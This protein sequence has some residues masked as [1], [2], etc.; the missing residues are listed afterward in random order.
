MSA[1][2]KVKGCTHV[3]SVR[4]KQT[5]KRDTDAPA[6]PKKKGGTTMSEVHLPHQHSDE[7][8]M[9][10][11]QE[12]VE[13]IGSFQTVADVFKQLSDSSRVRIFWLLCHCEECVIDLSAMVGMSSPAVSHHLRQLRES[14]LLVSRRVGKEVYYRAS[15]SEQ[16]QLLHRMIERTM[17]ISCPEEESK[18][19]AAAPHLPPLDAEVYEG[20]GT[21]E[22]I[23][24]IRAVH[25]YLTQ[26]LSSRVTIDELSR[27]FLMNPSTMKA[28]FKSVYGSSLASVPQA[29]APVRGQAPH[30]HGKQ[31]CLQRE[32]GRR[33][34]E[35][36]QVFHRIPQGLRRPADGV[37][38]IAEK[39][40]R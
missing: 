37:P 7:G 12:S 2:A 6:G 16:A 18:A 3:S 28:L 11:L 34:R 15:D 23:E 26:H 10:E 1:K 14:G 22:Q 32:L 21:S 9:R 24:T 29:A 13:T 20:G 25:D 27:M 35:P 4:A 33:L 40:V 19:A 30:A 38:E 39:V 8:T 5:S 31:G 36:E 17:E